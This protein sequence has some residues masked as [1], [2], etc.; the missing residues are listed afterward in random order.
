[1]VKLRLDCVGEHLGRFKPVVGGFECPFGRRCDSCEHFVI[2]GADY[3]YWKRQEQGWAA[4]AEGAPDEAAR[5]YIYGGF[6]RSSLALAG[7]EKALVALGLLDQA[8]EL[9]LRS[10]HQDFFDPIW[11]Q[12]W[13]AG[14]LVEMGGGTK[15]AQG[16]PPLLE[17]CD[18]DETRAAS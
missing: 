11:A 15:A 16:A 6:E 4:M 17:V 14:D 10:P 13:R 7:L 8:K 2:T 12:G 1:M 3:A 5:A 18:D 9:D